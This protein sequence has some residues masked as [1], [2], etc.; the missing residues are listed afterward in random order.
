MSDTVTL[1]GQGGAETVLS[2]PLSENFLNQLANGQIV[3]K[4]NADRLK[5]KGESEPEVSDGVP[6]G[7][8]S[9]VLTWVGDDPE[10]ASQALAVEEASEHP[11]STLIASLTDIIGG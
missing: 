3:P 7:T 11:R 4:T 2:L 9:Q 6:D 8:I 5:L 1:I 10:K